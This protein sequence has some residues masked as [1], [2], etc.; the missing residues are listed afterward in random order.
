M[1]WIFYT[2]AA[3]TLQTFRN[4]EQKALN[5]KLDS[6]TVSWSRFILPL[7]FAMIVVAYN[8]QVMDRQFVIHCL[9]TA[10]FQIAGN[11]F[12]LETI[13]S[14]N[15]SVGI[16]FYKT[17]TLQS[18]IIGLLFFGILISVPVFIAIIMTS[19]GVILMSKLVFNHGFKSFFQSLRNGSVF[20]GILTGFCFSISAFNLK[21]ASEILHPL[22]YTHLK[23][24]LIVLMLVICFQNL[25]FIVM[26]FYQKRLVQDFKTLTSAENKAAFFRSSI[27]S[28]A[29][30]LCWFAAFGIGEVVYVKA[31][32]QF[33]LVLALIVSHQILKEKIEKIELTGIILTSLGIL[34]LIF[35]TAH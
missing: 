31:V 4:L 21:F 3:T 27:L 9:V 20:Y 5:K 30:S 2:I 34:S 7:P 11:V 22:G 17:E 33:E 16:A 14:R 12:L 28:F 15:F 23:T 26:K 8:Y 1:L 19:F 24:A 29:G 35:L 25:F 6:L 18:M 10:F 32:G 13:K